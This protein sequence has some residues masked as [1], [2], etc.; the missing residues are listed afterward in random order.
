VAEFILRNE[1]LR[2]TAVISIIF[3]RCKDKCITAALNKKTVFYTS[4]IR[5]TGPLVKC[6]AAYVNERQPSFFKKII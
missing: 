6:F 3:Y 5:P 4:L 1:G 2:S